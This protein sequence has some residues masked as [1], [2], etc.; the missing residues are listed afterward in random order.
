MFCGKKVVV[1]F[2][3][4]SYTYFYA[5]VLVFFIFVCDEKFHRNI[6]NIALYHP[7]LSLYPEF[8]KK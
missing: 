5:I 6:K 2:P 7:V 1:V 8:C 4:K 3:L